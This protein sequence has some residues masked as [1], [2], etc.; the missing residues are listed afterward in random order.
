MLHDQGDSML[1]NSQVLIEALV[2]SA[3]GMSVVFVFLASLVGILSL[4]KFV[5]GDDPAPQARKSVLPGSSLTDKRKRAAAIAVSIHE[6][7]QT[8]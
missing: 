7:E 5:Q 6:F 8:R 1:S 3:V 2:L 4:L